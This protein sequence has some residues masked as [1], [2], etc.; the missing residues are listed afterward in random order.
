M[1]K[2]THY[3]IRSV[4]L[5]G[6]GLFIIKLVIS[7][8]IQ[9][10]IAPR[11]MPYM[12]FALGVIAILALIQFFKSDTEEETECNCGHNHDYSSSIFRSLLIYS[13][14]IIPIV[15]GMLFSDHVLGSS[16]AANKGFKYELRSASANSDAVRSQV[17]EPATDGETSENVH[18]QEEFDESA[19]LSTTDRY[20]NLYKELSSKE[21][22]T[23]NEDNFIGAVSLLEE[24]AD[25]YV[26]KEITMTGFVFRE[27]GFPEDRMVVGR[28]G[29][30]CCVADGGVYGILV[31]SNEKD[32]NQ[33][34]D[35]TWV[36][37]TGTIKKIEHNDWDLPM[38]E[39]TEINKIEIPNE[40]YV[41]EEFEFA[42]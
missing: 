29:I 6:F 42:G 7:G 41:Y 33:Y 13:L 14:F 10:F 39:P 26:G 25:D 11:M 32:F 36:E 16:Q 20:P 8:D 2:N 24:S 3:F 37:I 15:S 1:T 4:I 22:F 31:Q 19:V 27:D 40:P 30:S 28:F 21:S 18:E 17:K 34:K 5:L 9:K 35:D 23:L 12:Y 38:I